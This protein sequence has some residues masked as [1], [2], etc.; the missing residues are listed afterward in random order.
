[1]YALKDQD[2]NLLCYIMHDDAYVLMCELMNEH[3]ASLMHDVIDTCDVH[4][5]CMAYRKM[6]TQTYMHMM[7]VIDDIQTQTDKEVNNEN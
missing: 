3:F 1:M 7:N 5:E 6:F 4:D 2:G